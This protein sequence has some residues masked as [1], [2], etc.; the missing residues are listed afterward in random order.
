MPRDVDR[1]SFG[2]ISKRVDVVLAIL[3][4]GTMVIACIA[5]FSIMLLIFFDGVLR[6]V[7][8]SPLTFTVDIVTLYL[9]S[10][11]FL[12][13]V[14]YTL[15]H[16]GHI[17]VDVFARMFSERAHNLL[18]GLS[19]LASAVMVAIM[20]WVVS[21]IA[22]DSWRT[23]ELTVGLHVFPVWISKAIVAV[24]LMILLARILHLGA[25]NLT[26]GLTGNAALAISVAHAPDDFEEEAI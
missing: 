17:C 3:E 22:Y 12:T 14:S 4:K 6:Y 10:A 21:E 1:F 13:V 8:N 7:A 15:R 18:I 16:G 11:A 19:M 5:M 23:D 25:A 9:I 20:T 24:S 2:A 26:A